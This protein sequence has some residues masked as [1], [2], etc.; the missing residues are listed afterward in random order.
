MEHHIRLLPQGLSHA[1]QGFVRSHGVRLDPAALEDYRERWLAAGIPG[2]QIDRVVAFERTWGRIVLPPAPHYDG[3]PRYLC[4]DVP[5]EVPGVG[6][7]FEAG[8]QRTAVP[9]TFEIGPDDAFGIHMSGRWAQLHA[10]IEGWIEALSLAHHAA[11]HAS[12]IRIL[13]GPA[14]DDLDLTGYEEIR[15]VRGLADSWWRGPDSL[16]AVY[17]GESMLFESPAWTRAHVYA[18]IGVRDLDT[19]LWA[20]PNGWHLDG[21]TDLLVGRDV[22]LILIERRK[23]GIFETWFAHP[24]GRRL[25]FTANGIRVMLVLMTDE[26]DPG[27]HAIDPQAEGS[28]DGFMLLNGQNDTYANRDTVPFSIGMKSLWHIIDVG[29]WPEN[30]RRESDR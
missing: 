2:D 17:R 11:S 18:G 12:S 29:T 25:G 5:E 6:W 8:A 13:R 9:Y 27:E 10:S 16:I 15:A 7:L 19:H 14:A 26:D 21:S 30:V 22:N 1:A 28:S 3:G 24:D 23:Q 20:V 4:A